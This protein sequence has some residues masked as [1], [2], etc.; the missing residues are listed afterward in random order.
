MNAPSHHLALLLAAP[1]AG[2][3]AMLNDLIAMTQAL[4]ARGLPADRILALHGQLDQPLVLACLAAVHRQMAGWNSGGIFIHVSGHGFFQGDT[5]A[6]A[7]P[8]LQFRNTDDVNDD[9]HLFWHEFFDVLALP[10]GVG[11]TLLPD[12]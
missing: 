2:E 3:T 5:A 9:Y 6:T 4:Q 8:G 11:L 10:T 7:R 1:Q 12:L